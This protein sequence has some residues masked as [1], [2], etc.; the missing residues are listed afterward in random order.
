MPLF[1][2]IVLVIAAVIWWSRGKTAL[3]KNETQYLKRRGYFTAEPS[4]A[5]EPVDQHA[6][7]YS[8][9]ESL[10]DLSANARQRAAHELARL[11]DEG[12]RDRAMFFPLIEA[13]NDNDAGVRSAAAIALGKLEDERA[14][15]A[16]QNRLES[17]ESLQAVPSL[18]K[19][20][21]RLQ[22]LEK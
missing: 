14:I 6:R 3:S 11:C 15:A 1:I 2:L 10:G 4:R 20:L 13:L 5:D 19:A 12:K 22:Q 7:L 21:E 17:D 9:I 8:A 16:L 18:R